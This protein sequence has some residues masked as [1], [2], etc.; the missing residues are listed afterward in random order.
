MVETTGECKE[1]IDINYQGQW[2]YH[3]LIVSLAN[4]AE[5]LYLVNRG[6][7]RPSHEGVA[8]YFDKAIRLCRQAGFR[9]IRLRGDTDFTQTA[10]L[11]GWDEQGDVRFVFGINAM[12]N[13]YETCRR[14]SGSDSV[15]QPS[16]R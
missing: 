11:D 12:P 7:N 5:P 4:T 9:T 8:E 14:A 3:P 2:G 13:L 1:G 10:H 15:A 6:G 16:I